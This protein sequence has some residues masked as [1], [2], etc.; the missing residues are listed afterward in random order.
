MKSTYTHIGG[1][2]RLSTRIDDASGLKA[3]LSRADAVAFRRAV[4]CL[5]FASP[6]LTLIVP[7]QTVK[8]RMSFDG[9]YNS[10]SATIFAACG[11]M[12]RGIQRESRAWSGMT[13]AVLLST[14]S[15]RAGSAAEDR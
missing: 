4:L 3:E 11:T 10:S 9:S 15:F 6:R 12:E 14:M 1:I 7:V 2:E 5:S 13:T 8:K